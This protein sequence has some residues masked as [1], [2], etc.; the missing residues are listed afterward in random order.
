MNE[1]D[2]EESK[3]EGK[4]M[5]SLH[6]HTSGS[7]SVESEPIPLFDTEEVAPP[8]P[9][10]IVEKI[11]K[12]REFWRALNEFL[13]KAQKVE[14]TIQSLDKISE[15]L[16]EYLEVK[17]TKLERKSVEIRSKFLEKLDF[18]LTEAGSVAQEKY[19]Q[20]LGGDML[21]Y[22]MNL[23]HI[24]SLGVI[25][26]IGENLA[27]TAQG[28]AQIN[29]HGVSVN[30]GRTVPPTHKLNSIID[31]LSY[32]TMEYATPKDTFMSLCDYMLNPKRHIRRTLRIIHL[33]AVLMRK[34]IKKRAQFLPGWLFTVGGLLKAEAASYLKGIED[35][36]T[37]NPIKFTDLPELFNNPGEQI[38]SFPVE[39][40]EIFHGH[41][42]RGVLELVSCVCSPGMMRAAIN[43]GNE[44]YYERFVREEFID[45]YEDDHLK[46]P[47]QII[48]VECYHYKMLVVFDTLQFFFKYFVVVNIA[49]QGNIYGKREEWTQEERIK[50]RSINPAQSLVVESGL[51]GSLEETHEFL[52]GMVDE[53]ARMC[54]DI[55]ITLRL[56]RKFLFLKHTQ[57]KQETNPPKE[58]EGYERTDA[59]NPMGIAIY[60]ALYLLPTTQGYF[61]LSPT[62]L[63]SHVFPQIT[64]APYLYSLYHP[65]I[66]YLLTQQYT[67][68]LG[69]QLLNYFIA[70][71]NNTGKEEFR[72]HST[73]ISYN[74]NMNILKE[75]VNIIGN[76]GLE[77]IKQSAALLMP[78]FL[79]LFSIMV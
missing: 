12:I 7:E 64:S 1:E 25:G 73:A 3:T 5:A 69:L 63:H 52:I 6:T 24:D 18:R 53:G 75:M 67:S 39:E 42:C 74:G 40:Q 72:N 60:S 45:D 30:V 8:A 68:T 23:A 13:E 38:R 11:T 44:D 71:L 55:L 62:F 49:A 59:Y 57:I 43:G 15:K 50:F 22:I 29:I 41:M 32:K 78:H 51:K 14:T 46:K 16:R 37:E 47:E 26:E 33:F 21:A 9:S 20:R 76:K 36:N 28:A 77:Y 27:Y 4:T 79:G 31:S 66:F 65:V 35:S 61:R 48:P 19:M 56:W 10:P 58:K 17:I 2:S 54:P 34:L 70:F